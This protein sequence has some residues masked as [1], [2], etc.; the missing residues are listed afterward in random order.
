MVLSLTSSAS[1]IP[2]I[3]RFCSV[4][5]Q[6]CQHVMVKPKFNVEQCVVVHDEG[7]QGCGWREL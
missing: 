1:P 5:S 4:Q 7:L 6:T 3:L 2:H